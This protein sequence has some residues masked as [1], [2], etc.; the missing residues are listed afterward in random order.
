MESTNE[1]ACLLNFNPFQQI[2]G[3]AS[4]Q[5]GT[6]KK[7][8]LSLLKV[9]SYANRD[10]LLLISIRTFVTIYIRVYF[11]FSESIH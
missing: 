4:G 1:Q 5:R 3:T 8:G 7:T 10:N 2:F 6:Q 11:I 9:V